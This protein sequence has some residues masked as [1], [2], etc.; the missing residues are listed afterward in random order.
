MSFKDNVYLCTSMADTNEVVIISAESNTLPQ[1]VN[2]K[3]IKVIKNT[4]DNIIRVIRRMLDVNLA[5]KNMNATKQSRQTSQERPQRRVAANQDK[6]GKP[7]R[8]RCIL[9]GMQI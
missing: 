4:C 1:K 9:T 8:T 6:Y 3:G 5:R 2:P 7:S